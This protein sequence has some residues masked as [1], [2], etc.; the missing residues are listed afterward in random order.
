MRSLKQAARS[1]K[2]KTMHREPL[3][4]ELVFSIVFIGCS[5]SLMG[6]VCCKDADSG[7]MVAEASGKL[8]D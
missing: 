4:Y 8:L 6:W 3:A 7:H 2:R 1:L 5:I